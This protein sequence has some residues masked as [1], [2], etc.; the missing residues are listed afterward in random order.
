MNI[1]DIIGIGFAAAKPP[2][3]RALDNGKSPEAWV[4]I[5]TQ[6]GIAISERMIRERANKI[7]ARI[8]LGRNM[9]ITDEHMELILEEAGKCR[10]R[11]ISVQA[12]GGL[13]AG[14]T[15]S[16][17]PSPT[18]TSAAREHLQSKLR[19]TGVAAKKNNKSDSTLSGRKRKQNVR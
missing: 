4:E 5:L 14:S 1:T 18:T 13:K 7:G 6:K 8:K 15:I 12:N 3:V 11:R 17:D 9:L 2:K 19:G 10:S 16:V